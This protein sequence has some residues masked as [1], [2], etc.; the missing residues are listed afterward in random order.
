MKSFR[1]FLAAVLCALMIGAAGTAA[2]AE[3]GSADVLAASPTGPGD[4]SGWG[5]LPG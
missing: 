2:A 1:V 5:R 4:D 3:S